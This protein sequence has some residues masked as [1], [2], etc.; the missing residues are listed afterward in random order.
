MLLDV[1][2]PACFDIIIFE[3]LFIFTVFCITFLVP[4][5]LV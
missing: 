1:E 5:Y 3:F 2:I 4:I